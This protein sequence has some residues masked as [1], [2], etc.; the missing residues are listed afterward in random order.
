[1]VQTCIKPDCEFLRTWVSQQ[2]QNNWKKP[3][4]III[5][6]LIFAAGLSFIKI[7]RAFKKINLAWISEST[8]Y[9]YVNSNC[10]PVIH[11]FWNSEQTNLL[12]QIAKGGK[13][14]IVG[15]DMRAD[16]PGHCAKYG[17]YSFLELNLNK[18]IAIQLVQVSRN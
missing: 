8:Y 17:T 18:I 3:L 1:M 9:K 2:T 13:P 6:S 14:I 7:H 15:G 11:D 10:Y 16:S 5:P 4:N 12:E